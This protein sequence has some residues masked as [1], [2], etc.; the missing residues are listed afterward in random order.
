ME[1]H[2]RF[3]AALTEQL[4]RR[5]TRAVLGLCGFRNRALREY[6]RAL[7]DQAPGLP[8]AFLADPVFE[9]SFGWEQA[10]ASLGDLSGSLLH[11]QLVQALSTPQ[12]HGLLDDYSF[13]VTQHP[14]R[15]QLEA[16]RTLIKAG[17]SILVS[18]GTGSGKTECFLIPILNDLA[19]E[20][21]HRQG[22]PL[23]G[24]RALFLYPLNALIKSQKDRLIAWSEPFKGGVRFCLYNG[25]TP[26]Q[27]KSNWHCEVADRRTLRS[28]A[29]PLLITNATMLEYLLVRN[30]DRP[31]LNQ[32]QGTLRWIVI[33][34]AHTYV[35]SQAAELTLLLRR[36]LHAFGCRASEVRLIATS[37]T[38]GDASEESRRQLAEFLA[39]VAGVSADQVRV[40]EGQRATPDLPECFSALNQ[41]CSDQET[42][43]RLD[44]VAR[45][46][47]LA[48]DPRLRQLRAQL[49]NHPRLL[50]ALAQTLLG[51][52][53]LAARRETL[54]WL[55]LATQA[56]PAKHP[57]EAFL[58][59][60]GHL[61]HRTLNG[62]WACP[63]AQCPGRE[64][65]ELAAPDWPFG[66]VFLERREQCP[67]CQTPVFDL[68]QCREC[69]AEYLL[70]QETYHD[71]AD[72][73]ERHQF[74]VV[75]DEFQ[76]ALEPLSSDDED[77]KDSSPDTALTAN[78]RLLTTADA[79][80]VR[81]WRLA[82]DGRLDP[83]GHNGVRV[84]LRLPEDRGLQCPV[85][86]AHERDQHLFAPMRIGAP[87]LLSTAIPTLLE[88]MPPLNKNTEARPL[89]GRRLIT[90]T[91]SRQ[92]TARIAAKLQQDSE[93]DYVRSLLYHHLAAS[94]PTVDP[95]DIQAVKTTI[96]ALERVASNPILEAVLEEKRQEL[97]K[98]QTSAQGRLTWLEA[99][100]KLLGSEDFKRWLM[101]E[102]K[103]LTFGLLASDRQL[104]QLC[105]L[106]EFF[107]RPK[108][109]FSLEGLGLV[110]LVYP[111]LENAPLP[112]VMKRYGISRDEWRDLLHIAINH[113]VRTGHP[114][115]AALDSV[116]RWFGYKSR[117]SLLIPPNQLKNRKTQR[118][119][120]SITW[121][122]AKR[123]LLIRFLEYLFKLNQDDA[124]QGAQLEE[125]LK[126]IWDGIRPVLT[127]TEYGFHLELDKHAVLAQVNTAWLCPVTRRLLPITVRG[128]TP[129]LPIQP[130]PESLIHCQ[131]V[132][133]PRLPHPF[134]LNRT[135]EEADAWLESD[136]RIVELRQLG[137][138]PDLSD[139][140]ARHRRYIKA[141]EHSAQIHGNELTRREQAFKDGQINLLSCSTTMEMGVDIG[142]LTAVAMNNVP[143]HPAN[144]LQR[145]GR[146]GR[147][148]E[149]AALS[150]TLCKATPQ[151]EAVFQNPLWPFET[152]LRLPRVALQSVP[153]VQRHLNALT[154]ATFLRDQV[155]DARSVKVGW[156][157]E[158]PDATTS[159][160]YSHFAEWC[161]STAL[162]AAGLRTGLN[163]L[164]R[165]TPLAGRSVDSLLIQTAHAI[166]Q[167]GE[168][169]L[170]QLEALLEQ[171]QIVKTPTG[172]SKPEQAIDIQLKRLRGE[173]LL[174]E[175]ANL[176]FLP[177]YGFPT[178][179]VPLVTTTLENL[180]RL[181]K[182]AEREDNRSRR[183]GYP[184]RHLAIAIRDYAPGTDT[185]LDG[186]VYRSSGVTLN[187]QIPAEAQ[188]APEIQ[189]LR[190][191]WRCKHCGSTGTRI[192]APPRCPH[193]GTAGATLTRQRFI[194][195]A[196]FAVDIRDTPH[197]DVTTPQFI[198][199]LNPVVS[200][201]GADWMPLPIPA[202][203]R[204]RTSQHGSLFHRSN[205]LY[206]SGYALCLRCGRADSMLA[207]AQLPPGFGHTGPLN[208]F[209]HQRLRGGRLHDKERYCPGND[210]DWSIL[211]G[212]R[213]GIV[214]HTEL[215]ELQ[216]C[217]ADLR[218]IDQQTAYTLAV[219]LRRALCQTL[220]IEEAEVGALAAPSRTANGETYSIYLYDTAAGGAGYVSQVATQ[221]PDLLRQARAV[222]QCP[223]GCN[224][225][226]Q[227]CVLT[228]D[229][230]HQV[231]AL[232]RYAALRLLS[233][234]FLDALALPA[235]L[236]AFGPA[237]QLEME[238]LIV[239][240]NREAQRTA[241]T[242]LRVYLGGDASDWEPLA[243]RLRTHLA[244]CVE[245]EL[246]V[247]LIAPAVT[248]NALMPTQ[249]DE[250]AALIA[251]TGAD[252]W[253]VPN[254][255]CVSVSEH[256]LI[257]ELGSADRR[258][259]WAARETSALVPRPTWGGG[260]PG[261]P[262]V[263]IHESQPLSALPTTWQRLEPADLRAP[264]P[265]VIAL[266]MTRE[267]DGPAMT[268]G[269]RAWAH[270]TAQ[271][272][273]LAQRLNAA[274]PLQSLHY[275]DR[276]LRSPFTLL[277]LSAVL[278]GLQRY[279]GGLSVTTQVQI[280]TA[281]LER[282]S[283]E[284]PR[285][286]F[287]DW[288]D[289]LDRRQVAEDWFGAQW[290]NFTWNEKPTRELPHAREL[291]LTWNDGQT[292]S[293]RLD[294]GFGYWRVVRQIGPEFPFE[295]DVT[296]QLAKLRS[297]NPVIEAMT[298]DYPT[299]WYC[300]GL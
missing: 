197:N 248:L 177:G 278:D 18:S 146:A 75:E 195:P 232:N 90:F 238:P 113:V 181:S 242:E 48:S 288:C 287:H 296:R 140:L 95:S 154:L 51:C 155:P 293:M 21:A 43:R 247:H 252:V 191:A 216:L 172:D 149:S 236:S 118:T 69:G 37:A 107:L 70:A 258:V 85:C 53:D 268:F 36:V 189:D 126:A 11:P 228:H 150:F 93:R 57:T 7:L 277:L 142:G 234:A 166:E 123:N 100:N 15:H 147:R 233:D 244:R 266:S 297:T 59:L 162:S 259:R 276:Y 120:P 202:L 116:I 54:G 119:W 239:A 256:P 99:E 111:V 130:A 176:G 219:A 16:W 167:V 179:V 38:L 173:Y 245:L 94:V 67:H 294:Q 1:Q 88:A 2:D 213:L 74:N 68:V 3:Y 20:L 128:I 295:A 158:A 114:S 124:Y 58:P 81:D 192:T 283:S 215:F 32:S 139:R 129:Y 201:D 260:E 135:A 217:D 5:A 104:V 44:P 79:A 243:W 163:T 62:L 76:Q 86:H 229:T 275:V 264:L 24:V 280:E 250:L 227:G 72:W 87:F 141:A 265:G 240:L 231:E 261:G 144:F 290:P 186:R 102:L 6:L 211:S 28:D 203:G 8:G 269:E 207:D 55:D 164:C 151:G 273:G 214:T 121:P 19:I 212:I 56:H 279:S 23:T 12:R 4:S 50:S 96:Q 285:W 138:W 200:L 29:P 143:P 298:V 110:Q 282:L 10:E 299:Y 83:A 148:A 132:E 133:L 205:G 71:G 63:N 178:H 223:R 60:R 286:L 115:V 254:E 226:C 187:W 157:F 253:R 13:P 291:T 169:W 34:E 82:A 222:L 160:P 78:P 103:T 199:V 64:A 30:E 224:A 106:R 101:P 257:L 270:L 180:N 194:Q 134:W 66:A 246:A 17:R 255:P 125:I 153:I 206:G 251:Y 108:R 152:R 182:H 127:Q 175:L 210:A 267:L 27:G 198:P 97:A 289:A 117:P 14:Y 185:V 137:A 159:A 204:Y 80:M 220:G 237:S 33:D 109:Q 131:R 84:H 9:A 40:I 263:H 168:R 188:A 183:A 272:A 271:I 300:L 25:D 262:F 41:P 89:D 46:A 122:W 39:D 47:A 22:V 31:I 145:A 165:R 73:L 65:T 45:F 284:S 274:Q 77:D 92:G 174:G 235:A 190:W 26:D 49:V 52:D 161:E 42:V 35:G 170:R 292:W 225:A 105:L 171:R 98:L 184:S 112:A 209:P 249:R 196:G 241:M 61:F 193:C 136:P 281:T 91:D 156:F 218:P 208:Q 230:Q 221:L